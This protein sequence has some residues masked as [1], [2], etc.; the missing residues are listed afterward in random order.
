MKK[1][2]IHEKNGYSQRNYIR[3]KEMKKKKIK[4]VLGLELISF[5]IFSNTG[6]KKLSSQVANNF[7]DSSNKKGFEINNIGFCN[8]GDAFGT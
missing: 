5:I 4:R 6:P 7:K 8:L 1:R 3:K 2:K